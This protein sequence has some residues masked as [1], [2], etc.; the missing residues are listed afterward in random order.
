M[1]LTVSDLIIPILVYPRSL[2]HFFLDTQKGGSILVS[3]DDRICSLVIDLITNG[4]T[5]ILLFG[6]PCKRDEGGTAAAD[7]S[8]AVQVATRMIK[9][10]FGSTVN[11]ITDVCVC[12]YNISGHCG[13]SDNSYSNVDNFKSLALL[14]KIATSHAESGADCVAPSSMMDGQVS[15]IR[16]ALDSHGFGAVKI[17]SYSAKH[18]SSLYGPFRSVA[19][20]RNNSQ[21]LAF[22]KSAYQLPYSN[23]REAI[24]E[25]EQDINEGANMVMIKPTL[26]YLD[27]VYEV[28]KMIDVPLVV[29][30]VSGEYL[31]LRNKE[32]V[33]GDNRDIHNELFETLISVKHAGSDR[34]ITYITMD[35]L[36][37]VAKSLS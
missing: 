21:D 11:V 36:K 22:N 29:Q 16:Q 15:S 26:W 6:L 7:K 28:K 13:I 30:V 23:R 25:I 14:E 17:M 19:F 35:F 5:D 31:M 3:S 2:K 24:R 8:G 34:V 27:L 9:H 33:R 32:G 4:I 20:A 12:Q 37:H 18:A 1:S 10:D